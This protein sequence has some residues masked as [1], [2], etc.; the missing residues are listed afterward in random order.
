MRLGR[1]GQFLEVR[2]HEFDPMHEAG[3]IG[4]LDGQTRT[5]VEFQEQ[6]PQVLVQDQVHPQVAQPGEFLTP[7]GDV[8][9][10]LPVRD[11]E[12]LD[13]VAGVGVLADNLLAAHALEGGAAGQV[14][15]G[16]D[17]PLVEVGL[18]PG[19]RVGSLSMAITGTPR[20]MMIRTSGTPWKQM[21]SNTG[22]NRTR[23]SI[24]A[25]SVWPPRL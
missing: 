13:A 6:G 23:Y 10:R 20:K 16:P 4:D 15:A 9:Q 8:K 5:G 7:G 25:A 2:F 1:G 18:A 21:W 24:K 3:G 19:G 17:G 12:P 14:D 22:S 11:H